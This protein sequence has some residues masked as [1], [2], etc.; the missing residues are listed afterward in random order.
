METAGKPKYK[1]EE[2]VIFKFN[3]DIIE[4]TIFIVDSWLF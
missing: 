4:G 3:D 1:S 2:R